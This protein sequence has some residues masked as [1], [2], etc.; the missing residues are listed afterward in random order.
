MDSAFYYS[1]SLDFVDANLVFSTR[2]V[3]QIKFGNQSDTLE[4]LF[5]A[6]L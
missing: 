2:I 5:K 3:L 4:K 6:L 1:L